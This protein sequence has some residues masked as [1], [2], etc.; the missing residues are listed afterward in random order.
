MKFYLEIDRSLVFTKPILREAHAILDAIRLEH[1]GKRITWLHLR[2]ES[3]WAKAAFTGC[4]F[5]DAA[6]IMSKIKHTIETPV[7]SSE[8]C[9]SVR[10]TKD[11][12]LYIAGGMTEGVASSAKS[13]FRSVF[14][15][16]DIESTRAFL[17]DN[18]KDAL[19]ELNIY[20][21]A[22]DVSVGL[23]SDTI[24]G[25]DCSTFSSEV[26]LLRSLGRG[27]HNSVWTFSG[28]AYPEAEG[29]KAYQCDPFGSN[30]SF[31]FPVWGGVDPNLE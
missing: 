9:G 10:P 20:A 4:P 5:N 1:P 12:E 6:S 25:C 21:A 27:Q 23:L 13:L 16:K 24:V 31:N 18:S 11:D 22:I 2:I 7:E 28:P 26:V 14:V 30:K 29:L 8:T 17:E 3:D 19:K 15:A